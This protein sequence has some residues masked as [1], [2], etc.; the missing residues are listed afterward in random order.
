MNY[1]EFYQWALLLFVVALLFLLAI[2]SWWLRKLPLLIR[3]A[4]LGSALL[5]VAF[6]VTH[7]DL[8]AYS[9]VFIH[10]GFQLV[11]SGF[12]V[13]NSWPLLL[14]LVLALL[15]FNFALILLGVT[16]RWRQGR[17]KQPARQ[18]ARRR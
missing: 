3:V 1:P 9:P 5:L 17:V 15:L 8:S 11:D 13:A 18:R 12:D 2:F 4:M 16:Q 7:V 14:P 10:F 6:P